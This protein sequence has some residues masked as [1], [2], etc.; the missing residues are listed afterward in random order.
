MDYETLKNCFVAVFEHYKTTEKKIFVVHALRND[1]AEFVSFLIQNIQEEERHISY[2]G[3]GFDA[4]ITEY[5]LADW[6][7]WIKLTSEEIANEIYLKAQYVI[8]QSSNKDWLDFYEGNMQ[9]PQLDVFK[10]NHWDNPAK[11]SSLKWIQFSMDWHNLQDMP[12]HHSTEITTQEELDMI[13]H[14]CINDVQSTKKILYKSKKQIALRKDLTKEYKLNLYSASE[15]RISK[16]LF[17]H[18]LSKATGLRKNEIKY[19]RTK[20]NEIVLKNIILPYI[21]F[22]HPELQKLLE[23]FNKIIVDPENTKGSIKLSVPYKGVKIDYGLGGVHGARESG[24]YEAS[25]GMTIMTS[26]VTSYYPNLAIRNKWAPAHIPK[27]EFCKLYEWFF[28]ERKKIPK[29]DPRNYVYK[30]ILNSTYGLSNDKY[31]FL[32]DPQFTMQITVNG[33]LSLTM[34]CEMIMERIPGATLLM[35]NTD[36]LE[37]MIPNEFID[38]YMEVC[39]EWEEMTM[40]NLEHDEYQKLVLGDVNNYIAVFKNGKTKCKGRFEFEDLALHKNKSHLIIPKGIYNYFVNDI[41]PEQYLEQNRNIFDYCIGKKIK[42]AWYFKE[43]S[44][45]NGEYVEENLQKT[46]RYYV[47]K[48]GSKILKCHKT[49]GRELRTEAGKWLQTVFNVYKERPWEEYNVDDQYYLQAIYKE[50]ENIAGARV[51]QLSMF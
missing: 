42:G 8:N 46:I 13:I 41:P 47:S 43:L 51:K 11:R 44:T 5:I 23:D 19:S 26:D 7:D 29:S 9:I 25:E 50:I 12:I 21:K 1:F 32:Y 38:D 24:L 20:R 15:P 17:L 34:L 39:K 14:Y 40:L 18:F 16:E 3:L 6:E 48:S 31:S 28:E 49:D 45:Q 27:E 10:L 4:Q 36:G 30:I 22:T 35:L 33:Q 2:N 37:T